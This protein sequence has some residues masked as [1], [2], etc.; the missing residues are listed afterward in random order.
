MDNAFHKVFG[1]DRQQTLAKI[2]RENEKEGTFR[3]IFRFHMRLPTGG[4]FCLRILGWRLCFIITAL[5][6]AKLPPARARLRE[7]GDGF[8]I[9]IRPS[10]RICPFTGLRP[11]Q[12]QK[13]I[14]A[15]SIMV[16]ST[17]EEPPIRG[18]LT[19]PSSHLF[20]TLPYVREGR[21]HFFVYE[22]ETETEEKKV[23]DRDQDRD[24][25]ISFFL[26]ETENENLS[27]S[28]QVRDWDR[29]SWSRSETIM[30]WI[31]WTR[32]RHRSDCGLWNVAKFFMNIGYP[33]VLTYY[34]C[35]YFCLAPT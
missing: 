20:Y 6:T 26:Y 28:K 4:Q 12:V 8:K 29:E 27:L 35:Y 3:A 34:Y 10:C 31:F 9:C 2:T 17:G 16:S 15:Q 19:C 7:G 21:D 11:G 13:S 24:L 32:L 33:L 25:F 30:K 1:L 22:T 18:R 5:C 23:G 14:T